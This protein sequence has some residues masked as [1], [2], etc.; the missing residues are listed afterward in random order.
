M[1]SG[2][3]SPIFKSVAENCDWVNAKMKTDTKNNKNTLVVFSIL[4]PLP[5]PFRKAV[6]FFSMSSPA[7]VI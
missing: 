7:L 5:L 2:A 3:L 6:T 4:L 1:S